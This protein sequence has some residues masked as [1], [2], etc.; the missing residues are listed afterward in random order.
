MLPELA[1]SFFPFK[2]VAY[3]R[4]EVN[5]MKIKQ[6]TTKKPRL[7]DVMGLWLL[8]MVFHIITSLS[9]MRVK[10][11]MHQFCGLLVVLGYLSQK[12]RTTDPGRLFISIFHSEGKIKLLAGH[13]MS[14]FPFLL[15]SVLPSCLA[16]SIRVR[17]LVF[18]SLI[19]FDLL[20]SVP[21]ILYYLT[22]HYHI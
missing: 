19:L 14:P 22:F 12:R 11:L 7:S 21:I 1:V 6:T 2:L 17:P 3:L 9:A 15:I 4:V 8:L 13:K 10:E 18:D 5:L 16:F 20:A